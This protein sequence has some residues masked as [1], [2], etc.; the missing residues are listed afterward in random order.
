[1]EGSNSDDDEDWLRATPAEVKVQEEFVK[2]R[3]R[4]VVTIDDILEADIKESIRKLKPRKN[5]KLQQKLRAKSH[6]YDT[7][8]SEDDA[9]DYRKPTELF[10]ALEKQVTT[11]AEEVELEWGLPVLAFAPREP[12]SLVR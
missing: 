10:E 1:M 8:D 7:S 5:T 6:L 3:Q 4:K 12:S 2:K 9:E 11:V